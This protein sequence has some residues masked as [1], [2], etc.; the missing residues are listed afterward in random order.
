MKT[1]DQLNTTPVE[2][3]AIETPAQAPAKAS[4]KASAKG[5]GQGGK[6]NVHREAS[7]AQL[8]AGYARDAS[9]LAQALTGL[10]ALVTPQ[11][12][13]AGNIVAYRFRADIK[14][15]I[16]NRNLLKG[17]ERKRATAAIDAA[18]SVSNFFDG[19]FVT[20]TYWAKSGGG[21]FAAR[22]TPSEKHKQAK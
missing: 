21:S 18:T 3:P 6:G 7:K 16:S 13:K 12:S 1:T 17:T 15:L 20:L 2:I 22:K 8:S 9:S 10:G 19:H 11:I 5:E 14:T 4:A